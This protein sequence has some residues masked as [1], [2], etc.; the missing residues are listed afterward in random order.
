MDCPLAPMRAVEARADIHRSASASACAWRVDVPRADSRLEPETEGAPASAGATIEVPAT[1]SA[2]EVVELRWHGLPAEVEE[3]ELLLSLDGGRSFHVRL[4]PE[5]EGHTN[6]FRWHVPDLPAEQ[7]RLLLRIGDEEGERVG[8][9]SRVFRILHT[10]GAPPP[11][12][13]F[14]E[15]LTWT[16]QEPTGAPV[17][18][19]ITPATPG[20]ESASDP[21]A[22]GLPAPQSRAERLIPARMPVVDAGSV[23]APTSP[24]ALAVPR[25]IPL[26]I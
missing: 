26:R 23:P 24:A 25:E 5:L 1:V 13:A 3:M 7:A 12:L 15:G 18:S 22:S 11:D 8:A 20:F 21:V 4:T 9:L 19:S 6:A 2:G 14:H 17:P 16:G 10:E